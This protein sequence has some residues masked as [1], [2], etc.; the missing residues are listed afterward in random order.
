LDS[1]TPETL[2][3]TPLEKLHLDRGGKMVGFAGYSMPV[4]YPLGVLKEHLHTR[5]AAGLFDVS[6]MGQATLTGADVARALEALVP[7]DIV[8]LAPGQIRYYDNGVD[9]FI[10]LNTGN[11][12][13]A[14]AA[15]CLSGLH[16]P[17]ET[18]FFL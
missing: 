17:N 12:L 6:H 11:V 5:T 18:W 1:Q 4:N 2:K 13:A 7:G 3:R 15:I 14:D 16:T 8:G 10:E 9:T